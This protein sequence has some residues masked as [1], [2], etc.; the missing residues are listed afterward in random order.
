MREESSSSKSSRLDSFSE[1]FNDSMNRNIWTGQYSTKKFDNK[2][3]I[4]TV[5]KS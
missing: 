1:K 5:N 4:S 2:L 3:V